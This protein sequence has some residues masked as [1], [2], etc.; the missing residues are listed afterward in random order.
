MLTYGTKVYQID[1]SIS[2]S[3]EEVRAES[4]TEALIKY[5]R[6]DAKIV[7]SKDV[8][9]DIFNWDFEITRIR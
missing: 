2:G 9:K 4:A 5:L 6:Q 8:I 1:E 7:K 3:K